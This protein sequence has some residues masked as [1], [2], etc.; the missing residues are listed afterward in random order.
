MVSLTHVIDICQ[1][2][3]HTHPSRNDVQ[4]PGHGTYSAERPRPALDST[5]GNA[6]AFQDNPPVSTDRVSTDD[7]S[8]NKVTSNDGSTHHVNTRRKKTLVPVMVLLVAAGLTAA[9]RAAARHE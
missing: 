6:P 1:R 3:H 2:N 7:A 8:S 9:A 4:I 5:P